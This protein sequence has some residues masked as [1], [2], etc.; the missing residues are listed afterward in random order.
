M[1]TFVFSTTFEEQKTVCVVSR[2][3]VKLADARSVRLTAME[4][5][6]FVDLVPARY[7]WI[8]QII[9]TIP[10]YS[11]HALALIAAGNA[12]DRAL[13][14]PMMFLNLYHHKTMTF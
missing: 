5:I 13:Q 9:L 8:A 14:K 3:L 4:M 2:L 6:V 10:L 1:P 11:V 7:L 12:M